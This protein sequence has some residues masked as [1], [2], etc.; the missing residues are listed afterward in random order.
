MALDKISSFNKVIHKYNVL[1]YGGVMFT[2]GGVS[3][4]SQ[5]EPGWRPYQ[6]RCY[7]FSVEPKSWNQAHASCLTLGGDLMSIQTYQEREFV[8]GILATGDVWTGLHDPLQVGFYTWSDGHMTSFTHWEPGQPN[9]H[10]G[11]RED[12]VE[13]SAN[14]TLSWWN[15]LNCDQNYRHCNQKM[16]YCK[17]N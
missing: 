12:C 5:C 9:N 15:D 4:Y 16:F 3:V 17:I 14:G 13:I 11:F 6:G 10:D 8:S 2:G 1:V 7:Y